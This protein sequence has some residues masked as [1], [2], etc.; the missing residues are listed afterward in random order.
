MASKSHGQARVRRQSSMAELE[1]GQPYILVTQV[2]R[3]I[4]PKHRQ[5]LGHL[6]LGRVGRHVLVT[7]VGFSRNEPPPVSRTHGYA[8]D[9]GRLTTRA[10]AVPKHPRRRA[11]L[12]TQ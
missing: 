11:L 10:L 8:A 9:G 3:P 5:A 2:G 1:G 12:G 6:K 4:R 7:N